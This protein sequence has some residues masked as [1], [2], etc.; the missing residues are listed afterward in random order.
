VEALQFRADAIERIADALPEALGDQRGS[1]DAVNAI[2]G[3][4]QALLA[5]DVIYLQRTVPGLLS[6]YDERGIEERFPTDRFLPDLG[7]LDPDTVQTRLGRISGD[8]SQ[9]ATPGLHGTGIQTVTVRPA[10]V[11]LSESGVNR[12][13]VSDQLT[14]DVTVQNQ[15]ES[16]ETDL[17][18]SVAITNGDRINV[19]QTIPRIAAGESET[20]SIPIPDAPSTEAV[21]TATVAVAPVPGEGTRENNRLQYQVAFTAE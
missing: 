6:A 13:P 20:V 3:Q 8:G 11:E 16:E 10:D 18:V 7:W 14:F 19:D 12:V 4:M 5:S 17:A 21:S 2:A 1:S 9:E 15:G